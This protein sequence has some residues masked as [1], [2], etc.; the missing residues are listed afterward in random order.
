GTTTFSVVLDSQPT[1]DVTI[2]MS[3]NNVNEGTVMLAALTFTTVNWSAPQTVTVRGV[4]D[5]V[6]DG[7]QPYRI[8]LDAAMGGDYAG[9]DPADVEVTNVDDDSPGFIVTPTTGLVT[10]ENGATATF[11]VRLTSE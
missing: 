11:T 7:N 3:S 6:A 2:P 8:R 5:F 1:A 9:I 10:G 4:D